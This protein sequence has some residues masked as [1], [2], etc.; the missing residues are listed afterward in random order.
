VSATEA[1]GQAVILFRDNG[2]GIAVQ[3]REKIFEPFV[4]LNRKQDFDSTG[5]GLTIARRI[6]EAHGGSLGVISD[7]AAE[8]GASFQLILPLR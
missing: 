5:L 8:T 1:S 7:R 3:D 6:A 2:I 4:R